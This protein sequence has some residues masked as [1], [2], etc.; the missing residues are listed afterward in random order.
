MSSFS[1]GCGGFPAEVRQSESLGW[2]RGGR[3]WPRAH[4]PVCVF[5]GASLPMVDPNLLAVARGDR[6]A[7]LLLTHGKVVN[8]F[9]GRIDRGNVA[10]YG[11]RIAG[12]GD[13]REA[14]RTVDLRGSSL[15]PGFIDAHMHVESTMLPPSEFVRLAVPHGTTGVVLDPHEIANVLGLGGILWIMADAEGL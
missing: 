4:P 15:A 3:L 6:P 14:A 7:D 11:G 2:A 1:L 10:V 12:I 13:Y 9:T 8:V 5:L